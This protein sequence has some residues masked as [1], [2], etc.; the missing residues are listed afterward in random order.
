MPKAWLRSASIFWILILSALSPTYGAALDKYRITGPLVHDNLAIYLVHGQSSDAPVPVALQEALATKR[1]NVVE[2]GRVDQLMVE[3]L[4]DQ[5]VF[6]QSGDIVTGGRQDRVIVSSLVLPPHSGRLPIAVFCVEPGRWTARMGTEN[7]QFLGASAAMP[8]AVARTALY[9]AI[10]EPDVSD[11]PA[12]KDLQSK[13]WAEAKAVQANLGRRLGA[14]AADPSSPTSLALSLNIEQ[15]QSAEKTFVAALGPLG[16]RDDDVLGFVLVI[17]GHVSRAEI[18][19]SNA[20]FRAM[21]IKELRA[22]AAEAIQTDAVDK[23]PVLSIASVEK[24]LD[25]SSLSPVKAKPS[26]APVASTVREG[27]TMRFIETKRSDNSWV[28]R[29]YLAKTPQ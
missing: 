28:L 20:L 24:L 1:V 9:D 13:I 23:A 12:G 11:G 3:N 19:A 16:L 10:A 2:T 17:N 29:S 8:S 22:G 25:P 7:G 14:S 6:I 5:E 26:T 4:G 18:Y 21:W 15:L 27:A